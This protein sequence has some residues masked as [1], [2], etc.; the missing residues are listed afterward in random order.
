MQEHRFEPQEF[1]EVKDCN[2]PVMIWG[3]QSGSKKVT[4]K[5]ILLFPDRTLRV[6]EEH[7]VI[8][9]VDWDRPIDQ[10]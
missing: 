6:Y 2:V 8:R 7:E 3:V 4:P 9:S 5:Y 1:V 10:T